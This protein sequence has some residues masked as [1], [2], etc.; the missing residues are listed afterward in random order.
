MSEFQDV[1][2][3]LSNAPK[4]DAPIS[5]AS[6]DDSASTSEVDAVKQLLDGESTPITPTDSA[7]KQQNDSDQGGNEG[8]ITAIKPKPIPQ[9]P[10]QIDTS[11]DRL[12]PRWMSPLPMCMH[13]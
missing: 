9:Q 4:I 11:L 6:G 12:I 10:R 3:L 8:L 7:S 5:V 1:K 13:R 2:D